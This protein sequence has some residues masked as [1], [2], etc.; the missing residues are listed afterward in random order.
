MGSLKRFWHW[1]KA[2]PGKLVLGALVLMIVAGPFL[3]YLAGKIVSKSEMLQKLWSKESEMLAGNS[4]AP[5]TPPTTKPDATKP[6]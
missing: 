6:K 5:T 3:A 1:M 2:N 4:T